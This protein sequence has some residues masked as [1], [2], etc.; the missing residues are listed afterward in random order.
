M[1]ETGSCRLLI[2]IIMLG[3]GLR[4]K[5]L[6]DKCFSNVLIRCYYRKYLRYHFLIII[7]IIIIIMKR[8]KTYRPVARQKHM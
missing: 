1:D 6:D 3:D 8:R 7:M 5:E 2:L 4:C